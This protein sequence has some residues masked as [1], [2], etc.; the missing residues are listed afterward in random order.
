M[1]CNISYAM[2]IRF[3]IPPFVNFAGI[4]FV[5]YIFGGCFLEKNNSFDKC[6]PKVCYDFSS[7]MF[8]NN[9][10]RVFSTQISMLNSF[11]FSYL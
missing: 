3:N 9:A 2:L 4:Q 7:F 11:E 6:F 8:L 1:L 10:E 5:L